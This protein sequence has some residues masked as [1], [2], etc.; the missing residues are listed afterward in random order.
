MHVSIDEERCQG[1]TLCNMAAPEVFGLRVDDGHAYVLLTEFDET[2]M[3]AARRGASTCPE[4][5]I[6][7]V[8]D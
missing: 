6:N 3:A 1:H 5:A 7:I 4:Q 8:E 2:T